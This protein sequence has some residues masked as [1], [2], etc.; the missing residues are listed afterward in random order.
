[1]T[2]NPNTIDFGDEERD[3]P[4]ETHE[5]LRGAGCSGLAA[6]READRRYAELE[7]ADRARA[8]GET[9]YTQPCRRDGKTGCIRGRFHDGECDFTAQEQGGRAGES[10]D[11]W[12]RRMKGERD[13]AE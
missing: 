8:P 4:A 6:A 3:S 5:P 2:P 9:A 13:A 12:K 7:H 10:F 1:M 11:D